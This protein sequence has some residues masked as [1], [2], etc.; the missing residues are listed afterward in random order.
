VT[1]FGTSRSPVEWP[2]SISYVVT[3][4][5]NDDTQVDHGDF[6]GGLV[7][8]AGERLKRVGILLRT[9]APGNGRVCSG[10]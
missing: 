1:S 5:S 4:G 10:S 8:A 9:G 7:G 2:S 6:S 3:F